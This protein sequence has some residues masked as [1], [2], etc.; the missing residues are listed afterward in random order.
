M[1]ALS[2]ANEPLFL[3]R[4]NTDIALIGLVPSVA[5]P[6][7]AEYACGSHD[8]PRGCAWETLPRGVYLDPCFLY[9]ST[10][11]RFG[12]ELP[13]VDKAVEFPYTISKTT[14]IY[15]LVIG[16]FIHRYEF[17]LLTWYQLL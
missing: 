16:L 14:T 8:A 10:A 4:M 5:M 12:V 6:I 3:P 17:G 15:D 11:P 9:N 13:S 7:R 1:S 2:L